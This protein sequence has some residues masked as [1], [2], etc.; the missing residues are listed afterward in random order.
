[1]TL[2]RRAVFFGVLTGLLSP[3]QNVSFAQ[4]ESERE[5]SFSRA[6]AGDGRTAYR[7]Y[8][9]SCHGAKLEGIHLSPSLVGSR[10]DWSWR[11]KSVDILSFHVRRMPP[12]GVPGAGSISDEAYT[13]IVAYILMSNDFA[14]SDA[15]LSISRL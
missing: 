3:W 2:L 1:M 12:E 6:Q 13:N 11:G 5:P 14:P 7:E 15:E 8:C 10:F 4:K 9:A